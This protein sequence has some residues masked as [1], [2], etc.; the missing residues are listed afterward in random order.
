MV[1]DTNGTVINGLT[2]PTT[3]FAINVSENVLQ[4]A[5]SFANAVGG[6]AIDLTALAA[7]D[8]HTL[9]PPDFALA[10]RRR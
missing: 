4:L 5:T 8:G 3:Y 6:T 1:Y 9:T 2:A 10:V 7:T